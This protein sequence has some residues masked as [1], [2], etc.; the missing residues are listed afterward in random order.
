[1]NIEIDTFYKKLQKGLAT[2]TNLLFNLIKQ[3]I[4]SNA[5][6]EDWV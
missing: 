3:T 5:N 4:D 1:M 2:K 6:M